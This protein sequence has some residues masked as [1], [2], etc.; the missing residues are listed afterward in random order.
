MGDQ[1]TPVMVAQHLERLKDTS[2]IARI[3]CLISAELVKVSQHQAYSSLEAILRTLLSCITYRVP[4]IPYQAIFQRSD[5]V[6]TD[7][8]DSAR[9]NLFSVRMKYSIYSNA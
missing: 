2:C 7:R 4:A 6:L 8:S 5:K 9:A 1:N 3:H